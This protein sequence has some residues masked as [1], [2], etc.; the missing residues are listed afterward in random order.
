MLYQILIKKELKELAKK[1]NK[2]IFP[3]IQGGPLM[4]V[5]AAKAVSFGEALKPEFKDYQHRVVE[6]AKALADANAAAL[7]EEVE[8]K[9]G[10]LTAV[11]RD[12]LASD[13]RRRELGACISSFAKEDACNRIWQ[14]IVSLTDKR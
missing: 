14:D 8:L 2:A 1:F 11:V 12:L 10:R 4:H 3:G 7:V 6:N 5:I 9:E 13:T